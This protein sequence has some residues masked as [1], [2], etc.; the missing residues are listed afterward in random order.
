[1]IRMAFVEVATDALRPQASTSVTGCRMMVP[2]VLRRGAARVG[3]IDLVMAAA[4]LASLLMDERVQGG[5]RGGLGGVRADVEQLRAGALVE[6]LDADAIERRQRAL[7]RG[8]G[9]RGLHDFGVQCLRQSQHQRP[10]QSFARGRIEIGS[11]RVRTVEAL[12][13]W[14]FDVSSA[15]LLEREFGRVRKRVQRPDRGLEVL[16]VR[17]AGAVD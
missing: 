13:R 6:L 12:E 8:L 15:R 2:D 9:A 10:G 16:A 4:R 1:M 17:A 3:E 11:V 7:L 5:N 14:H